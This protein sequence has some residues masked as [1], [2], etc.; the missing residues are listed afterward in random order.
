M[1]RR[2]RNIVHSTR[3][4][5]PMPVQRPVS[6]ELI[7]TVRGRLPRG[8]KAR[9]MFHL[10]SSLLDEFVTRAGYP[11][12][13]RRIDLAV[14]DRG[15]YVAHVEGVVIDVQKER[16][17][18]KAKD[19]ERVKER[20]DEQRRLLFGIP[21]PGI[22]ASD[23]ARG[24]VPAGTP[25]A[26]L[27]RKLVA[28]GPPAVQSQ[29][30]DA[31][32]QAETDFATDAKAAGVPA[33]GPWNAAQHQAFRTAREKRLAGAN[34][35]SDASLLDGKE[36]TMF[37]TPALDA[38][39]GPWPPREY[40]GRAPEGAVIGPKT[41][42]TIER[43]GKPR[44]TASAT[45]SVAPIEFDDE[46]KGLIRDLN[47]A[48]ELAAEVLDAA[49]PLIEPARWFLDEPVI[50]RMKAPLTP[51]QHER[52]LRRVSRPTAAGEGT[53][54]EPIRRPSPESTAA[55]LQEGV[56]IATAP[57]GGAARAA[58][59]A[60]KLAGLHPEG[61]TVAERT[62]ASKQRQLADLEGKV[63]ADPIDRVE[64]RSSG[65]DEQV[66]Q[67]VVVLE[68]GVEMARKDDE[69]FTSFFYRV[70]LSSMFRSRTR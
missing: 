18:A 6:E 66:P 62:E 17:D 57:P 63:P 1:A 8:A 49:K 34:L 20:D 28:A 70:Y 2:D 46:T 38:A 13:A 50:G 61:P 69:T 43:A 47:R 56:S 22:P 52:A 41:G 21:A 26:D 24:T 15:R 45:V 11:S 4:Y 12:R 54:H 19:A 25:S 55:W 67:M 23:L 68:S 51:E 44:K 37:E 36:G 39:A 27:T 5:G 3:N 42:E 32:L 31:I 10:E 40:H 65:D 29:G 30:R 14:D 53:W 9:P 48:V 59:E 58:F 7:V 16:D 33:A 64:V 60:Q 35:L